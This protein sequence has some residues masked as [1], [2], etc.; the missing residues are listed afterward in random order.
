M[1]RG[2]GFDFPVFGPDDGK[3]QQRWPSVS[4]NQTT[5]GVGATDAYPI[6]RAGQSTC[7]FLFCTAEVGSITE[8]DQS[9]QELAQSF[10]RT[11]QDYPNLKVAR[12]KC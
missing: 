3:G 4:A 5:D 1:S 9:R 11:R 7:V 8:T 12:R 6:L 10:E 2:I